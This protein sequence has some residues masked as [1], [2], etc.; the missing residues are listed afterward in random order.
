M[1]KIK[2]KFKILVSTIIYWKKEKCKL[3]NKLKML[4]ISKNRKK[5]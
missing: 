2:K 3:T 4:K 1:V 5:K